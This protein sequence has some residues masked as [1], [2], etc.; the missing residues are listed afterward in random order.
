MSVLVLVTSSAGAATTIPFT[1]TMSEAVNITGVPQ[2]VLDVDG[3]TRYATYTSGSGSSSLTFTYN[4]TIGDIDLNGISIASTSLD[5]NGGAVTDLNGNT[6]SN[7]TFTA[8]ANMA[9]VNINYPSLSMDFT[10]DNDGRFV[11]SGTVYND[12]TSFLS[13]SGGSFTR[14]ST[15]TYFDSSGTLQTA[16]SN[17]PRFDYDPATLAPKGLLLEEPRINRFY[18]SEDLTT[19]NYI[20]ERASVVSN[21]TSAPTGLMTADKLVDDTN[22]GRHIIYGVNISVTAGDVFT[23]S[24][25]VKPAEQEYVQL[26]FSSGAFTGSTFSNFHLTGA[27]TVTYNAADVIDSSI[28]YVGNGW[29]R[30]TLTTTAVNTTNDTTVFVALLNNSDIQSRTPGYVGTGTGLY[31]WGFQ[32]EIGGHVTSYIPTAGAFVTRNAD[33][34]TVPV[35]TWYN[36]SA[37]TMMNDFSWLT[38]DIGN[39]PTFARFDDTTAN[40]RWNITY[41]QGS[42][43]MRTIGTNG[44]ASQGSWSVAYPSTGSAKIAFAQAA[45]NANSA[46]DGALQTADSSWSPPTVTRLNLLGLQANKWHKKIK[47]YPS[48]VSDTQLQLLSQ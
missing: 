13:A 12:F 37:G 47:Y 22:N 35:G 29:Y 46:F 28:T 21:A 31:V 18:D 7:L 17:I 9:N 34:L 43:V 33:Q 11:L 6:M 27:G 25:F 14:S 30:C 38:E 42:S 3:T 2:I 36:Q 32:S 20:T 26:I 23:G 19:T 39:S 45:N 41:I 5:L 24:V 40:N 16:A 48:R 44:G 10:A 1:V 4:A 15:A 8:P